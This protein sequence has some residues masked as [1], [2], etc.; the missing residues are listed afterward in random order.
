MKTKR[1]FLGVIISLFLIGCSNGTERDTGIDEGTGEVSIEMDEDGEYTG[2]EPEIAED[3]STEEADV[4][5]EE[6]NG[7]GGENLIGERV[8]RT[9]TVE[10]ET[11]DFQETTYHIMNIVNEYGAYVEYSDESS[12]TPSGIPDASGSSRQYRRVDY[13]LRVP[14]DSLTEFLNDLDEGDAYKVSEQIGSEDVTQTYRDIEAR[15]SVLQNKENRLSELLEQA[16]SIED[17]MTIED[18]LSETIAERESLQSR[19]ETYDD[20]IDFSTVHVMVEERPRVADSR[21]DTL[22]FWGRAQET[23]TDS[24]YTFYYWIQDIIIGIISVVPQLVILAIVG[25]I[26]WMIYKKA[27]KEEKK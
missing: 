6:E 13:T 21:E 25:L 7:N 26:G 4:A 3:E 16:E 23:F 8:I 2:S 17:I 9:A 27:N 1:W 19:L 22:S 10:Y 15:V 5:D 12:Y 11:L 24:M 18:N 14:V 20:L